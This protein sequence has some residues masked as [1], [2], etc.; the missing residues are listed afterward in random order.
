MPGTSLFSQHL[1][2]RLTI[3]TDVSSHVCPSSRPVQVT[4]G[5]GQGSSGERREDEGLTTVC[6][7][8]SAGS[9]VFC[10]EVAASC[11]D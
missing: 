1:E 7:L 2:V 6:L 4:E 11:L 8:S 3:V 9:E 5:T 10:M